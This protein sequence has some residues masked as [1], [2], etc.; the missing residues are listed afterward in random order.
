MSSFDDAFAF[1]IGE[2][3]GLSMDPKDR[4]NWDSGIVGQGNLKG[5]KYG[6]SAMAY[7]GVDIANLTLEQAKAIFLRDYWTKIAGDALPAPIALGV[8]DCAVNQGVSV[9][10]VLLQKAV[11]VSTDGIL[12]AQTQQAARTTPVATLAKR[13]T[14]ARIM[15]Y[16]RSTLWLDDGPNWVSRS[17]DVLERMISGPA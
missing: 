10:I 9:A 11:G 8:F 17:L 1:V 15:R 4:G 16:T 6:V 12:G 7:P 2:E 5:T 14:L 3:G 13:F